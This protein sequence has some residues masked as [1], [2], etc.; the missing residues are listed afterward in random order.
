MDRLLLIGRERGD[1][2]EIEQRRQFGVEKVWQ[3]PQALATR[4][5]IAARSAASM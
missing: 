4:A 5:R 1:P 3:P 2:V